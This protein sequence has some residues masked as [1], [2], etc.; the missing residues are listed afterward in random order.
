MNLSDSQKLDK[1]LDI[2]GGSM[3]RRGLC[4]RVEDLER[5]ASTSW[6]RERATKALDALILGTI[7]LTL[8]FVAREGVK[9]AIREIAKNGQAAIME[10][11]QEAKKKPKPPTCE[12]CRPTVAYDD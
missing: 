5:A 2:V 1:L 6:W 10:T 8:V 11:I 12:D 7:V 4:H 9:A 3:E